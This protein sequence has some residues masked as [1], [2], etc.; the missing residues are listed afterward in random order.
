VRTTKILHISPAAYEVVKKYASERRITLQE[1]ANDLL[2]QRGGEQGRQRSIIG[3][4]VRR[5]DR[6]LAFG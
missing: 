5:L 3:R 6:W 2:L 1:A 4:A